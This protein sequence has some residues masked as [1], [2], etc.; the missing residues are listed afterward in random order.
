MA[1][2]LFFA[3]WP[4]EAQQRTLYKL[5]RSI[6]PP[7]GKPMAAQNLHIT[8]AFLGTIDADKRNC[9]EKAADAIQL[10]S[11]ELVL[12]SAGY[13]PRP[14]VVWLGCSAVPE[15]LLALAARLNGAMAAC[16][17]AAETRPYSPHLTVLRKARQGPRQLDMDTV[18]W[19][20]G[21]FVLVQSLTLPEGA[22]YQV[23]RRW[24]L[25]GQL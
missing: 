17:L 11:F 12:D 6:A 2:R 8:L 10:P 9:M 25:A 24:P 1:E 22:Q 7:G 3:L 5:G 18:H 16:G 19:P 14:Q 20:V 21:D 13:W 23:V 4:D 15:P